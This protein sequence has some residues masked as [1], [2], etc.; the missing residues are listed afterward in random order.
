MNV[1]LVD[2]DGVL[3]SWRDSFFRFMARKG[4]D[5]FN[6]T[7][8][9]IHESYGIAKSLADD[10]VQTFN[11]S[12]Y[13]LTLSPYKDAVKYVRKLHDEHGY[14]FHVITSQTSLDQAKRLRV[15]NLTNTFGDVF[16]G[17]T[18]LGTGDDKD[19]ALK[20]WKDS[21]LWWIEDKVDNAQA[22]LNVGLQPIVMAHDYNA[23]EDLSKGMTY[24]ANWRAVYATIT[25]EF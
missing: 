9:K 11:E 21:G 15:M 24:C 19:K 6:P 20:R 8:Y 1:I 17:F 2:A 7:Y 18:I 13:M 22:G 23:I 3:L 16:E 25:G 5:D 4:Y 12:A 14:K 10:L